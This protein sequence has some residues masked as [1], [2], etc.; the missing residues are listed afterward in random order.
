MLDE[1]DRE[2]LEALRAYVGNNDNDPDYC[3]ADYRPGMQ[4]ALDATATGWSWDAFMRE[5]DAKQKTAKE[6]EFAAC[7]GSGVR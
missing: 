6:R 7:H 4:L 5:R 2:R 3:D 1:T